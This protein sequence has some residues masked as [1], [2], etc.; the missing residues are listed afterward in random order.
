MQLEVSPA[1]WVSHGSISWFS[2]SQ[3]F[4][5]CP[6]SDIQPVHARVLPLTFNLITYVTEKSSNLSV[7]K[8]MLLIFAQKVLFIF[9]K[10][11]TD[12]SMVTGD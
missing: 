4:L 8:V 9:L 6:Y 5:K 10:P 3:L 1:L 12:C 7:N 11:L 2:Q